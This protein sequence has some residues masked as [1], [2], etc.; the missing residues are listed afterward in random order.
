M[1]MATRSDAD[2]ETVLILDDDPL[3]RDSLQTLLRSVGLNTQCY[4]SAREVLGSPPAATATCMVVDIRMPHIGGLEFQ[5]KLV[6]RGDPTPII[7]MTGHGDI[8]MSVRAMKA[9]AV[10]FLCKPFRDQE[11]LDA[12]SFA[13]RRDRERRTAED[14]R[15]Q[16]CERYALLTR[17]EIDVLKG[18]LGGLLNK[19]I[20]ANLGIAEVTVKLHRSSV[21]KKMCA[22]TVP[23]LVRSAQLIDFPPGDKDQWRPVL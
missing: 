13:L 20:A 6:D 5:K 16:A 15:L 9:G 7:F 8:A 4:A 1:N 10:D 19:Q 14:E 23:D 3:V 18:V 11:M 22:R 2:G 12:I 21:M 17:R